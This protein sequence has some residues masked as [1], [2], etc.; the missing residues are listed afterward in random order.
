ME[1]RAPRDANLSLL[2][3]ALVVSLGLLV[4]NYLSMWDM[5]STVVLLVVVL[6]LFGF[7]L[8]EGRGD[9]R[10]VY[11]RLVA[12]RVGFLV[13]LAVLTV[14]TAVRVLV[15]HEDA[16]WL[17][18]ALASMSLAKIFGLIYGRLKY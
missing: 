4:Y 10:E 16:T 17:I 7:T 13:G 3:L 5:A 18:Y 12:S 15:W 2:S 1:P 11:H 8:A 9:E 14:G 6:A